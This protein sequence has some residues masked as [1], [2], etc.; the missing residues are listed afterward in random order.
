MFLSSYPSAVIDLTLLLM[1]LV[2]YQSWQ[3]KA[4]WTLLGPVLKMLINAAAS[5]DDVIYDDD[6]SDPI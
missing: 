2:V 6:N 5:S 1:P 3:P 4:A